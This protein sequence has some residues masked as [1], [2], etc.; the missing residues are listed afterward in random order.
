MCIKNMIKYYFPKLTVGKS[1]IPAHPSHIKT[2]SPQPEKKNCWHQ[3]GNFSTFISVTRLSRPVVI[4]HLP[5]TISLSVYLSVSICLSIS[6]PGLSSANPEQLYVRV[7]W[8][9]ELLCST[10]IQA[11]QVKCLKMTE[12]PAQS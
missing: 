6:L 3:S 8:F 1:F 5:T 4:S 2:P 10:S 11:G 9:L 12:I 7:W